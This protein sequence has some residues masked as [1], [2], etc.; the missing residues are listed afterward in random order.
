M[1]EKERPSF[2]SSLGFLQRDGG[3]ALPDLFHLEHDAGEGLLD[4]PTVEESGHQGEQ[5]RAQVCLFKGK[6]SVEICRRSCFK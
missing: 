6:V 4:Q 1:Q 5:Q 3:P 2:L